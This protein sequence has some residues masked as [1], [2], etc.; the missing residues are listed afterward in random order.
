MATVIAVIVAALLCSAFFSGMETAFITS[1]RLK[2]ELEKK[3]NPL[4]GGI[5]NIFTRQPGQYITT[6]LVGNNIALVVY[7]LYAS[8]LLRSTGWSWP[9]GSVVV[10]TVVSTIV[11]I[12]LAEY[13]PK[14]LTRGNPNFYMTV[15]AL[16]IFIVYI[17][18][19][20]IAKLTT[21]LSIAILGL[22]GQP[23]RKAPQ[24][25]R[26]ERIDL[27]NLLEEAA[28]NEEAASNDSDLELI[29]NA[30]DFPDIRVRDC[31]VPRVDVE[32][33]ERSAPMEELARRFVESSYSR[34]PVFDGTV[35]N[36]VGYVTSKSL[37]TSPT[38]IE[39]IIKPIDYVAETLPAQKMLS[40]FTRKKTALAVVIDEFGGTAGI[41]SLEDIL[42]EIFGEIEDEHDA[43]DMVEKV[44]APGE[45]VLSGRL[46]VEYLNEKYDLGI[47]ESDQY[48]TLAGYI[49]HHHQVIPSAG[50][51]MTIDNKQIRILRVKGSRL[52]LAKLKV[53]S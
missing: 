15:F 10:E 44:A 33:V 40:L 21:W 9:G 6:I 27:E 17:L 1:N 14:A 31:M 34:L 49:I 36:I 8:Q 2:L 11:I 18:L 12:F 13:I 7:S 5:M 30:L 46:E 32:A 16:P 53:E 51:A 47:E 52:D 50:D 28:E 42:E 35:D 43:P 26:F 20:P 25:K 19:Y 3:H 41:V 23:M 45:Y 22:F 37:F 4:L 24:I 38:S 29:R 48:N 39:Q